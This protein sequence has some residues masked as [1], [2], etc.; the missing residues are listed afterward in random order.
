MTKRNKPTPKLSDVI[1]EALQD[2]FLKAAERAKQ[3]RTYLVIE[4]NH[5]IEKISFDRIDDF[6]ANNNESFLSTSKKRLP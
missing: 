3:T 6:I 4:K 5:K 1:N 2:A